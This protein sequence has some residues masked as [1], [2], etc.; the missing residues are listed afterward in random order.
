MFLKIVHFWWKLTFSF[1]KKLN[2]RESWSTFILFPG[3]LFWKSNQLNSFLYWRTLFRKLHNFSYFLLRNWGLVLYLTHTCWA[4]S[5]SRPV[6]C[7]PSVCVWERG[8][9]I[10]NGICENLML[11]AMLPISCVRA[12]YRDIY[13]Y[14]SIYL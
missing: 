4:L 13:R 12:A 10:V 7:C 6:V 1:L 2:F 11:R 3:L 14:L 9:E 8:K 5:G